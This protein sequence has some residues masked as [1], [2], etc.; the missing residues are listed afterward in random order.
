MEC[1]ICMES[2]DKHSKKPR[3]LSCGHG[4]C[5]TCL[6]ELLQTKGPS[7]TCPNCRKVTSEV[8]DIKCLPAGE[9]STGKSGE[10][11]KKYNTLGEQAAFL[12]REVATLQTTMDDYREYLSS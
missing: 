8:Y 5:E 7:L 10:S 2:Y 12:Q 4:F 1:G 6:I 9:D 11:T 3:F